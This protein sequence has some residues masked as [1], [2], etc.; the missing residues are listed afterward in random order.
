MS[1]F[2][3]VFF[4]VFQLS[5]IIISIH[6]HTSLIRFLSFLVFV[7]NGISYISFFFFKLEI[8]GV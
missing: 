4:L 2:I 3:W 5:F 6:V 8:V 7:V 1:P